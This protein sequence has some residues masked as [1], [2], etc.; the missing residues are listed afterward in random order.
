LDT[1]KFYAVAEPVE[2]SAENLEQSPDAN[3]LNLS[4]ERSKALAKLEEA[5]SVS[6]PILNLGVRDLKENDSQAFVLGVSIPLQIF[7]TNSGNIARAKHEVNQLEADNKQAKLDYQIKLNSAE[8]E[9]RSSYLR[10][11]TL[12]NEIIKSAEEAFK[13][14]KQGYILGRFSYLDVLDTQRTLFDVETQYIESL[15]DYHFQKTEIERLTAKQMDKL[16]TPEKKN[17]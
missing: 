13:L 5:N 4:L 1:E 15:K 10:A 11:K 8:S 2:A 17:D 9:L 14:A 16:E 6:D 3:R 7:D 12:K